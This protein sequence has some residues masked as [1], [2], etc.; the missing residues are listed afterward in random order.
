[1][2]G[3]RGPF[4]IKEHKGIV[5]QFDQHIF[6]MT[7]VCGLNDPFDKATIKSHLT[8]VHKYNFKSDLSEHA[9]P[10][11]PSFALGNEG[12]L[13]LCSWPKGGKLSLPFVYSDE[14]WTGIEYQAAS[15]LMLMGNV[16]TE[17]PCWCHDP[18]QQIHNV[19]P[20]YSISS[21]P[22]LSRPVCCS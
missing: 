9:N 6:W 15:H 21:P 5:F 18:D 11:L 20:E 2:K 12:G 8:A 22:C 10:Q 14:V 1:M 17:L 3:A 13:L 7:N 16:T 19:L 4:F